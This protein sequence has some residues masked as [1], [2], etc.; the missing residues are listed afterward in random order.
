MGFNGLIVTDSLTMGAIAKNYSTEDV[1]R[2]GVNAGND[3]LIFCGR[4]ELSE[5]RNIYQTFLKLVKEN[6]ISEARIDESVRKILR[7]K[8]KYV[9]REIDPDSVGPAEERNLRTAC[10]RKASRSS[11]IA[12]L[13][14]YPR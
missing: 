10:R 1:I 14:L 7:L 5:Q 4:A 3:V 2:L 11:V 9:S 13:Y 6:E 8:E 12:V